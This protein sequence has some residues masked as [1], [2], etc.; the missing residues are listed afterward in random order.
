MVGDLVSSV[1]ELCPK[2]MVV[3]YVF[4][5]FSRKGMSLVHL[6]SAI[7]R[8]PVANGSRVPVCPTFLVLKIF[9]IFAQTSK[10]VQVGGL[11]MSKNPFIGFGF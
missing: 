10:L 9:F 6:P 8:R 3:S 11:S 7:M 2:V 4:W 1:S 5:A